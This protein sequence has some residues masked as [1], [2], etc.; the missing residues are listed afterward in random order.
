MSETQGPEISQTAE[1]RC[2]VQVDWKDPSRFASESLVSTRADVVEHQTE[3]SIGRA[4]NRASLMV[5]ASSGALSVVI[6]CGLAYIQ[7][8]APTGR[9]HRVTRRMRSHGVMMGSLLVSTV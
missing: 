7:H 8:S 4:E 1:M 2:F 9:F 5:T 6:G 3:E